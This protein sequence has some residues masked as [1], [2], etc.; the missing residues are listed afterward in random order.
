MFKVDLR[1]KKL[2]PAESIGERAVFVGDVASVSLSARMFPSVYGDAV[3]T[4]V[5][6]LCSIPYCGLR[7]LKDKTIEPRLE[8]V[9]E[10]GAQVPFGFCPTLRDK[11]R[12]VPSARPCSLEEYLVCYVGTKNGIK[13]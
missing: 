7:H 4:G 9:L 10:G 12:I 13:D 3:Y 8:F 5:S 2:V 11:E 1:G 6:G